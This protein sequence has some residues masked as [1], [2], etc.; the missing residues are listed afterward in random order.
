MK[1]IPKINKKQTINLILY[2]AFY[3]FRIG[4][5]YKSFQFIKIKQNSQ[6]INKNTQTINKTHK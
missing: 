3:I 1:F 2:F 4:L 5:F 6:T